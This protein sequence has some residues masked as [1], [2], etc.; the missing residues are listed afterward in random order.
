[1]DSL[2]WTI[3]TPENLLLI[4]KITVTLCGFSK[5]TLFYVLSHLVEHY[6]SVVYLWKDVFSQ[7][8]WKLISYFPPNVLPV[9]NSSAVVADLVCWWIRLKKCLKCMLKSSAEIKYF[10]GWSLN[11]FFW[12]QI[13]SRSSLLVK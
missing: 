9:Y 6:I 8:Y 2:I 1:M 4:Y 12:V 11:V 3:I 13:K 7:S 5:E 10:H